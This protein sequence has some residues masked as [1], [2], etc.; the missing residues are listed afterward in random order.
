MEAKLQEVIN[1]LP[2]ILKAHIYEPRI[3]DIAEIA[4]KAGYEQGVE[5][6]HKT[7]KV[8][9][10]A[11]VREVRNWIID[12]SII[13]HGKEPSYFTIDLAEWQAFW[14]RGE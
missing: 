10:E 3:E 8:D 11:G 2:V 1:K 14:K 12:H 5:D 4:F 13:T 7:C 6:H 9:Y